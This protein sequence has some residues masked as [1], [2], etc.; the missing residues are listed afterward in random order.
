MPTRPAIIGCRS[1][2][3]TA[4]RPWP[5]CWPQLAACISLRCPVTWP[6]RPPP[7]PFSPP[8]DRFTT[9]RVVDSDTVPAGGPVR[10]GRRSPFRTMPT[11]VLSIPAW[12]LTDGMATPP[13]TYLPEPSPVPLAT[14]RPPGRVPA[15]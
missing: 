2:A 4:A 5:G 15:E 3:G 14:G 7:V 8:P 10:R 1:H 11:P 9:W 12:R 13:A 6:S